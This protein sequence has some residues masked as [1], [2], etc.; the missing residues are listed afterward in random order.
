MTFC[1]I[2]S[3]LS[4]MCMTLSFIHLLHAS[5][6]FMHYFKYLPTISFCFS[7]CI[8]YLF[9]CEHFCYMLCNYCVHFCDYVWILACFYYFCCIV[10]K[11][12]QH[13]F[14]HMLWIC[15]CYD[16]YDIW[17]IICYYVQT[18]S[19]NQRSYMMVTN[20]NGWCIVLV[21]ASYQYCFCVVKKGSPS[22][23]QCAQTK[24]TKNK[25]YKWYKANCHIVH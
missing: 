9:Y 16:Y 19:I 3:L 10:L 18:Y 6:L 23:V 12:L 2:T 4:P 22:C 1:F 8:C 13:C 11:S 20:W 5:Q 7:F 21:F 24:H 14:K 17:F 15:V 25:K